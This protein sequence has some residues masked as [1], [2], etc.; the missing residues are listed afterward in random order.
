MTFMECVFRYEIIHIV[1]YI[2]SS[3]LNV[4]PYLYTLYILKFSNTFF[5]IKMNL[6]NEIFRVLF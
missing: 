2:W 1:L 5:S 4:E 3:L 6:S